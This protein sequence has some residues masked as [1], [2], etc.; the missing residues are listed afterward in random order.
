MPWLSR[1]VCAHYVSNQGAEVDRP[2]HLIYPMENPP[3][4]LLRKGGHHG[5]QGLA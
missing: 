3:E 4:K 2:L 1:N 5:S